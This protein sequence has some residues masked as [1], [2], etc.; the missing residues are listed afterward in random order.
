[1]DFQYAAFSKLLKGNL[2]F[3]PFVTSPRYVLDV[4]AGTGIWAIDF[5]AFMSCRAGL[6]LLT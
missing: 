6:S 1:M 2:S 4:C 3:A 5:G